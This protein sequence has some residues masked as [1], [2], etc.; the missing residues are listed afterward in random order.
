M[1]LPPPTKLMRSGVR[2]II[3]L[4]PHCFLTRSPH[5][6][7]CETS[8]REYSECFPED[9]TPNDPPRYSELCRYTNARLYNQRAYQRLGRSRYRQSSTNSPD[10]CSNPGPLEGACRDWVYGSHMDLSDVALRRESRIRDDAGSSK[11]HQ[12][13]HARALAVS[14]FSCEW[15]EVPPPSGTL[16]RSSADW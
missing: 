5:G 8:H 3:M 10:R 7:R 13:K 14:P 4:S 15:R 1:S 2:V 12:Q 9:S 16:W 6:R 11:S